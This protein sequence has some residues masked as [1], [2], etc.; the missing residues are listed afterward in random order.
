MR[1]KSEARCRS[2]LS[3]EFD[4]GPNLRGMRTRASPGIISTDIS[5]RGIKWTNK[6]QHMFQVVRRL[7][8]FRTFSCQHGS[9]SNKVLRR[10]P[11]QPVKNEIVTLDPNKFA[12]KK[13]QRVNIGN[14]QSFRARIKLNDGVILSS[15]DLSYD[16]AGQSNVFYPP[17]TNAFLYYTVP[18]ERP[19][20]GGELRLRVTSSD[21]PASF[22]SGSDLLQI[23]GQPW[24][25]PL[26]VIS[27][28]YLPLY[29][30]LREDGLVPDELDS[31]LSA[32]PSKRFIYSRSQIL[33]TL[34][35]TFIVDFSQHTQFFSVITEQG[36]E[37]LGFHTTFFD[38]RA[39]VRHTPY[40]GAY[41][42]HCL[43]N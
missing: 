26:I 10:R 13:P 43:S 2:S 11:G 33:Y 34:N 4:E 35:D 18:S 41:T 5:S 3:A 9:T 8:R 7:T 21:D 37:T 40:T 42:N 38:S 27:K 25:R 24:S 14:Q 39:L 22:A 16:K 32:L 19:R 12:E 1:R 23:N 28:N 6:D 17:D 15:P 30:K 31:V 36:M 29:A 20:I